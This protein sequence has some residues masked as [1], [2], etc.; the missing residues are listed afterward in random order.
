MR[1]LAHNHQLGIIVDNNIDDI[2]SGVNR[3]KITAYFKQH[4]K[5][6]F[7]QYEQN[8][9]NNL[10]QNLLFEFTG[11]LSQLHVMST[12]WDSTG[13][14]IP[15]E[16]LNDLNDF[17]ARKS[18]DNVIDFL[19]DELIDDDTVMQ[20]KPKQAFLNG[21]REMVKQKLI[22]EAY[23]LPLS[24]LNTCEPHV[25]NTLH[26]SNGTKPQ[27]L[28]EVNRILTH[29]GFHTLN[30]TIIGLKKHNQA[31]LDYPGIF[32]QHLHHSPNLIY[33]LPTD[34]KTNCFFIEFT[35]SV[36]DFINGIND[37]FS[38][39]YAT[40][41]VFWQSSSNNTV[42][43][44]ARCEYSI[45]RLTLIGQ[46]S[47]DE[48]A[49]LLESIW[50]KIQIDTEEN[51]LAIRLTKRY[52][53]VYR[54]QHRELSFSDVASANRLDSERFDVDNEAPKSYFSFFTEKPTTTA[55]LLRPDMPAPAV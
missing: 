17:F 35:G 10:A 1:E 12:A 22:D 37:F 11:F 26:L 47:A 30:S 14:I 38:K 28:V 20:V 41:I 6:E 2:Y 48:K 19:R 16:R 45:E 29:H 43:L 27:D 34:L 23:Y 9:I 3:Q 50:N 24:A 49:E 21:L 31:I 15:Y 44:Q 52:P 7:R 55:E 18:F 42:G 54:G 46:K 32:I 39:T 8:I 36:R 53:V 4:Y 40:L 25:L 51:D 5:D 33:L 13:L